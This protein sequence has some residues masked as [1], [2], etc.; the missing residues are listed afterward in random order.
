MSGHDL[1]LRRWSGE[2]P[3]A[4]LALLHDSVGALA[5]ARYDAEQIEA[6]LGSLSDAAGWRSR[7][8]HVEVTVAERDGE[9]AGFVGLAAAGVVDLL[10]VHPEHA[11]RGVGRALLSAAISQAAA[12]CWPQLEA[13]VSLVAHPLFEALGFRIVRRQVVERAGRRLDNFRMRLAPIPG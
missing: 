9:L 7:L 3:E 12:R 4:L 13:D 1:L 10:F 2:R 6:W 11:R 8:C 5:P